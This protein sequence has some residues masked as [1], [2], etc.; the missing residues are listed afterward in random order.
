VHQ[1][2]ALEEQVNSPEVDELGESINVELA[3][4]VFVFFDFVVVIIFGKNG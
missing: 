4:W 1:K 3:I 2:L